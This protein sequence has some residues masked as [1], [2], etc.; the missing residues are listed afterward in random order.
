M[1]GGAMCYRTPMST[2]TFADDF[3]RAWVDLASGMLSI[4]LWSQMGW[5]EIKQ[6]Y[7]RSVLGPFWITISCGALVGAMGPLYSILLRQPVETYFPYVAIGCVL[8]LMMSSQLS[9]SC[10]AF[11]SSE[12]YI[13]Q[14]KLPLTVHVMRVVWRNILI[15]AHNCV[16]IAAVLL[17]RPPALDW[18]LVLVP[19]GFMALLANAIWVGLLLGLLCARFRDIPLLVA[20]ILQMALFIT[21]IL[22]QVDMLG[23]FAWIAMLNPLFHFVEVIRSPLLGTGAAASSWLGIL[24]ITVVGWPLTMYLF[25]RYRARIAYWV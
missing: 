4:H 10:Q 1:N 12:S 7:R 9:D 13:K 6:R 22:W 5:Q 11:I 19:L 3:Q 23:E 25:A 8:W 17:W 21:P 20:S 18:T 2:K 14:I 24:I 15:F 16:V